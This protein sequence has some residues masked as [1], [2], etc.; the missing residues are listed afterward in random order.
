MATTSGSVD[1]HP[2]DRIPVRVWSLNVDRDENAVHFHIQDLR[3]RGLSPGDRLV[4]DINGAVVCGDVS[5]DRKG[6]WLGTKSLKGWSH[7][8]I[9]DQLRAVG[10][11]RPSEHVALIVQRNGVALPTIDA[12]ELQ[13]RAAAFGRVRPVGENSTGKPDSVECRAHGQAVRARPRRRCPR[14]APFGWSM[15]ALRMRSALQA[16]R[17]HALPRSSSRPDARRE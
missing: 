4:L 5:I 7:R 15:R 2:A 17:R 10:V 13:R 16:G 11:D 12:G 3:D 1:H 6:P 9:T 14:P 8:R